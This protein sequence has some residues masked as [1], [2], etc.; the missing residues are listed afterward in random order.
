MEL[1]LSLDLAFFFP[2]NLSIF[3]LSIYVCYPSLGVCQMGTNTSGTPPTFHTYTGRMS[4]TFVYYNTPLASFNDITCLTF[5]GS[6]IFKIKWSIFDR[7]NFHDKDLVADAVKEVSVFSSRNFLIIWS[8]L[9]ISPSVI[10]TYS[11]MNIYILGSNGT[12]WTEAQGTADSRQLRSSY[13][14]DRWPGYDC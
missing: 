9:W 3:S 1:F 4:Q 7:W 8:F 11:G 12:L 14:Y 5:S 13:F 6:S 2:Y 10:I